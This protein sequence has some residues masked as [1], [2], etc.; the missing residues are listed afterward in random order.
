MQR[1]CRSDGALFILDEMITGFRWHLQGAQS[2]FG[3]EPD[4][5]T[6]GKGMANGFSVAAPVGRREVMEVGAIDRE[7]AERTFLLST[8][9]GGEMLSLGALSRRCVSTANRR[10]VAIFGTTA[11]GCAT[12]LT[13]SPRS[14]PRRTFFDDRPVHQPQLRDPR[15]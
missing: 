13:E 4:M 15:P 14:W 11:R 6:F 12:A 9:H 8:T 5:T 7:G 3:V 10:F 1:L 2:Y